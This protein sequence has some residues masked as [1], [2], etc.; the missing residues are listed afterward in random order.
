MSF[1]EL[2]SFFPVSFIMKHISFVKLFCL[3]VDI[4]KK[5]RIKSIAHT[6]YC[7]NFSMDTKYEATYKII[8]NIHGNFPNKKINFISFEHGIRSENFYD[9]KYVLIYVADY[10]GVLTHVKY[11]YDPLYKT[12]DNKWASPYIYFNDKNYVQK[13]IYPK[14]IEFKNNL[15]FHISK[16]NRH[17]EL[18][19]PKPY[20]EISKDKA[21]PKY[22]NFPKE[23]F[24]IKKNI[25]TEQFNIIIK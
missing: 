25:L 15:K 13:N 12:E 1:H 18:E 5:I 20:Y 4:G 21:I 7:D 9:F 19:F 24:E 17:T 22:G 2:L 23:L 10:C 16:H 11:Q 3:I 8:E 6:N 14:K